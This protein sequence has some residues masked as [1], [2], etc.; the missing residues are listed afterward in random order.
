MI[1]Q[2]DPISLSRNE[3][4]RMLDL[5]YELEGLLQLAISR[6]EDAPCRLT[7]LMDHKLRALSA[8]LAEAHAAPEA[9]QAEAAYAEPAPEAE[10]ERLAAAP[11]ET[12]EA[13]D[14]SYAI[15]DEDDEDFTATSIADERGEEGEREEE[16]EEE[17]NAPEEMAPA[18]APAVEPVSVSAEVSQPAPAP[19]PQ[20]AAAPVSA[21]APAPVS[22]PA[23]HRTAPVFSINDRFL[24]SREL[25]GGNVADFESALKEVAGM[26]CYEEA[27]E[28]FYTDWKFDSE[29]P[30]VGEFLAVIAKF[31]N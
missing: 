18:P 28:Y 16:V 21:P 12:P 14:C 8:I 15:P 13:D 6:E 20:P 10:V 11:E 31:F 19:A 2:T 9:V 5:T 23:G 29:S 30:V 4:Q 1:T 26:E 27:E 24:F 22:A 17:V 3:M 7:S 25:F